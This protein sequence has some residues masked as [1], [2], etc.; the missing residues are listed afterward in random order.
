MRLYP[1]EEYIDVNPS[2]SK[3][4]DFDLK[5]ACSGQGAEYA[6]FKLPKI[7]EEISNEYNRIVKEFATLDHKNEN[8]PGDLGNPLV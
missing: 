4:I 8:D 3:K 1:W 7:K 5:S 2:I 6:K